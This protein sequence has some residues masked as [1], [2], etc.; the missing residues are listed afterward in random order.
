MASNI[1]VSY[2]THVQTFGWQPEV[3]N[4]KASGTTGRAKR[5]EAIRIRLTGQ[6]AQ[7]MGCQ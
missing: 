3:T 5:L 1:T 6:A 7:Q 2:S 4:G